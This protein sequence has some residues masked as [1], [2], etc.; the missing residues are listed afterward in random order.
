MS[1]IETEVDQNFEAFQR[2]LLT[3]TA[4]RGKCF[5]MRRAKIINFY[6][7]LEEPIQREPQLR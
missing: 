1:D 6:D 2:E 7:T 4:H 5:L 3:L